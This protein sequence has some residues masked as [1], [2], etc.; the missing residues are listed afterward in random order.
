[1]EQER[2]LPI[3]DLGDVLV[4]TKSPPVRTFDLM[5]PGRIEGD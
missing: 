4:E 2:E 5:G 3:V 1:M